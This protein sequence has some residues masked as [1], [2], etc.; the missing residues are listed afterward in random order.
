MPT[1]RLYVKKQIRVDRLNFNQAQ[2]LKLGTVALAARKNDILALRTPTGEATK[3]LHRWYAIRKTRM[4]KGNRR[5]LTL[6]GSML[7]S[8]NVRTV[9]ENR[10][11]ASWTTLRERQKALANNLIQNF[12]AHSKN[13]IE[14]TRRAGQLLLNESA[15]RLLVG[16]GLRNGIGL[17]K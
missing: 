1:I 8:W 13:G 2:M 10:A 12:V 6:T 9:S 5:N 11:N 16:G 3:P 4:G 7:R 17:G 15:K 14:A